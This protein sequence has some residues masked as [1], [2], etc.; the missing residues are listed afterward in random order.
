MT[1][2]LT[3][4]LLAPGWALTQR[5]GLGGQFGLL[6]VMF[7]P[8]LAWLAWQALAPRWS[9]TSAIAAGAVGPMSTPL[10]VALVMGLGGLY[11]LAALSSRLCAA[12]AGIERS[13]QACAAGNLGQIELLAG[14]DEFA[15]ISRELERMSERLSVSVA[16]IRS[17]AALVGAAGRDVA[18]SS[19]ELAGQAQAQAVSLHQSSA[20]V[21]QLATSVR[22]NADNASAADQLSNQ[23]SD[24]SRAVAEVMQAALDTMARIETSSRRMS[25]I[26]GVID[27]IA[28]QT[29]ILALNAA[30]EAARAGESG[31]G[32]AVVASEV[33]SLAHK[34]AQS[35][36]EIRQLIA[37][38]GE[39][40]SGGVAAMQGIGATVQ[41]VV[42][43]VQDVAGRLSAIA[44]GSE[45]QSAGLQQVAAGIGDL[46]K[47]TEAHTVIVDQAAH[48][49]GQMQE[50]AAR[51]TAAVSAF[52]LRQGTADEALALVERAA[53]VVARE[54]EAA[55]LARCNRAGSEFADRDLYIFILDRA[56]QYLAYAGQPAKVGLKL[57]DLLGD[58]GR[59]LVADIWAQA[60][61]GPGWVD[62]SVAHP[63]TGQPQAKASRVVALSPQHVLGCGIYKQASVAM[64]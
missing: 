21:Q 31:R 43:G 29:N 37:R 13:V 15:R 28:F 34:S 35:A 19:Q 41:G 9:A 61:Q 56:G 48:A 58:A 39:E 44:Q 7:L 24:R 64:A 4:K 6:A 30:V 53:A 45:L 27:A 32:F 52:R 40:V 60:D 16:E 26:V 49:A 12:L 14:E 62:Y 8:A 46:E 36:G 54:G 2:S 3:R 50:R 23:V 11:V 59:R 38:S 51:L 25:D 17:Q 63:V 10:L 47:L 22:A 5:L 57:S 33:R 18:A 20:A 42:G 1:V 55:L